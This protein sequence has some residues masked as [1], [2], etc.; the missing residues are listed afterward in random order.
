MLFE[1]AVAVVFLWPRGRSL[2]R[3]RDALLLGFCATTYA[4][5]TVEGF[6]WLLLAMGAA[7]C[8]HERRWP[9]PL[10]VGVFP[11]VLVHREVPWLTLLACRLGP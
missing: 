10:Y 7:Q 8:D 1:A 5:A 2:S 11:L 3:A 6:G 4:V 9:V